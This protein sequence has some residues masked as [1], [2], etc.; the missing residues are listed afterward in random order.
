MCNVPQCEHSVQRSEKHTDRSSAEQI[1]HII[2]HFQQILGSG[3]KGLHKKEIYIIFGRQRSALYTPL[4]KL[5]LIPGWNN[6][7]MQF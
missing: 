7:F 2:Q 6:T 5:H 1:S 4:I 3:T